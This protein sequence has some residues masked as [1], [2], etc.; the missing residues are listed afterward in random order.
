MNSAS[1]TPALG[2]HI[3]ER[4]GMRIVDLSVEIYE[5]MPIF[6]AHQR[7]FVL[8]NQT[9]DG[10]RK[11]YGTKAGFEAH[12]WIM[13]EHTGT[14]TDAILEYAEDGASI[15]QMPLEYFY[16]EA[17][18]LDVS[19]VRHPDWITPAALQRALAASGQEIRPGD[20]VLLYTGHAER[21]FPTDAYLTNQSGLNRDGA[22]WL[23]ERGVV[24]IGIDAVAIDH[25][26][27]TDFSGHMVCAEYRIS[28]TENLANLD[29]VA[30]RRF[31]YLGLPIPFRK[32]TGSPIR[33]IAWLPEQHSA[34]APAAPDGSN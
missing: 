13:S 31:I 4:P 33:A 2:A 26:D 32:G 29:Q 27:D 18:C 24:N 8:V 12:N 7:P 11:R 15:E 20:I 14:H 22:V 30:G 28:N 34:P 10:W 6:P 1:A 17:V 5:G 16:G 9:H 21:T 25:S 23:A 3:L 19:A